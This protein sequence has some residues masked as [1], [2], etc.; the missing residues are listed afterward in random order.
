MKIKLFLV[1]IITLGIVLRFYHLNLSP[2]GFYL[3]EAS[4]GYNA[5]SI[6]KTGRDEYGIKWPL[7]F[8]SFGDFRGGLFIY[9]LVPLIKWRGLEVETIRLGSAIWGT[10]AIFGLFWLAKLITNN[11][12]LSLI[13]AAILALMPWHLHF[14]RMAHEAI[15][16]PAAMILIL[17]CWIKFNR[18]KKVRW[19]W[20][21]VLVFWLGIFTYQT[22]KLWIPLLAGLII[23]IYRHKLWPWL[24]GI[25][26]ILLTL[27]F[28]EESFP[29]T[30]MVRMNQLAIW[31]DQPGFLEI[32]NRFSKNFI[33]HWS[34]QF[35]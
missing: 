9:S 29:G 5:Y 25:G 12:L 35:V 22:A 30:T 14:S 32:I 19:G 6:I 17:C 23:I 1:L 21:L 28:W 20:L 34:W 2:P 33:D 26:I 15:T 7:F 27:L 13:S 10:A 3:D 4:N 11:T 24:I 31:R 16:L 8:K 18:T